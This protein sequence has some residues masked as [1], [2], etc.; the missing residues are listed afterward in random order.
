[1]SAS[2][3]W[4]ELGGG[5]GL[6]AVQDLQVPHQMEKL[7]ALLATLPR[8]RDCFLGFAESGLRLQTRQ[9]GVSVR[10]RHI[11]PYFVGHWYRNDGY[12]FAAYPSEPCAGLK[13]SVIVA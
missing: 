9:V 6:C 12:Q 7:G 2:A 3:C 13:Y 1:M 4:V 5:N 10:R 11:C 8:L